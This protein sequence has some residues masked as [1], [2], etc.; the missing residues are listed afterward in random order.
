ME[1]RA[2]FG[3]WT[4]DD[5]ISLPQQT[6]YGWAAMQTGPWAQGCWEERHDR[7]TSKVCLVARTASKEEEGMEEASCRGSQRLCP[8]HFHHGLRPHPRWA[9]LQRHIF[10]ACLAARTQAHWKKAW[11]LEEENCRC[12]QCLRPGHFHHG[13]RPHPR[14]A[15][16][17][18]HIFKAC[19]AARTA[20]TQEEGTEEESCRCSQRL[21]P[22]H[23]HHGLHPWSSST[24]TSSVTEAHLQGV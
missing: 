6:P 13:L 3:A 8:G 24:L 9:A 7:S 18:R 22:G 2:F 19:L 10:K 17:Q 15:V 1:C 4:V 5:L 12:S 23:F 11:N 20:S 21:H 16:L 14:W